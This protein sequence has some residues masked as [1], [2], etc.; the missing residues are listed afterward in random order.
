MLLIEKSQIFNLAFFAIYIP[1][2]LQLF[3]QTHVGSTDIYHSL[4][5][6]K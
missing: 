3:E 1:Y 4:L 2:L 6:P 5:V